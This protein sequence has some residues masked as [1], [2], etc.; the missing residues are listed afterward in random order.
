MLSGDTDSITQQVSKELNIDWAKGRLLQEDKLNEVENLKQQPDTK[1]AF[2]GDG[3][4]DAPVFAAS[5]VG[6]AMGGLGSDVAIETADLIIQNDQ[7]SKIARAIQIG[8][9]THSIVWQTFGIK[10]VV[11]ILGAGGL[12][13]IWEAVYAKQPEFSGGAVRFAAV[14]LGGVQAATNAAQGHL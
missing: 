7:L 11:L 12:A 6:I 2:I 8:R 5:D 4:N 9:S 3:I 14:Q 10:V 13:S 1:V